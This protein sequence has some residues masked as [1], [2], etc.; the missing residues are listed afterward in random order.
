M[1]FL[2]IEIALVA[3]LRGL[4][5]FIHRRRKVFKLLVV[6]SS[7]RWHQ[8]WIIRTIW[9]NIV[10]LRIFS[11]EW[12]VQIVYNDLLLLSLWHSN[13]ASLADLQ[14]VKLNLSLRTNAIPDS[15]LPSGGIVCRGLIGLRPLIH[16]HILL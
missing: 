3:Q 13:L 15:V 8:P 9:E 16:H 6:P 5:V 7:W 2:N 14:F 12:I 1:P 4:A 10:A 11:L